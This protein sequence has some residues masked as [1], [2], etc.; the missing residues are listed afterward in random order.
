MRFT[1]GGFDRSAVV[2]DLDTDRGGRNWGSGHG[3]GVVWDSHV[4]S[5]VAQLAA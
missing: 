1:C 2:L 3:G 5:Q 4:W